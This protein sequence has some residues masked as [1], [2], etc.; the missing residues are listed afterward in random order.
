MGLGVG[1]WCSR[2]GQ[3]IGQQNEYLKKKYLIFC[4]QQL[5]SD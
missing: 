5:L 2:P 1:E 4:S 3:Q